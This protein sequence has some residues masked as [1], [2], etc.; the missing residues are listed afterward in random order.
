[1]ISLRYNPFWDNGSNYQKEGL[2]DLVNFIYNK[3]NNLPNW[4]E[5]GSFTGESTEIFLS[6]KFI[7]QLYAIDIWTQLDNTG[8]L[9]ADVKKEDLQTIK[10]IFFERLQKDIN[11]K[12]CIPI[13]GASEKIF[14]S[15]KKNFDVVYV[16]GNH[17]Y[18]HVLFN[19][20]TWYLRINKN[21]FICGHDYT[22]DSKSGLYEST[23]AIQDFINLISHFGAKEF[24]V[25]K[26]GSWALQKEEILD[27]KKYDK[28]LIDLINSSSD[29]DFIEKLLTHN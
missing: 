2:I 28:F 16:D 26:D 23:S 10:D 20:L 25:F 24:H 22:F 11:I 17:A 29:F 21:G 6:F 12:R 3:N 19:L 27:R 5:I 7:K 1:M 9:M 13:E 8:Y 14:F 18:H 15:L 4:L